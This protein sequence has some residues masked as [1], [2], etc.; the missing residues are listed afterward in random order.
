MG[1]EAETML[2]VFELTKRLIIGES[3][4]KQVSDVNAALASS[5]RESMLVE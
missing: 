5:Y 2:I 4:K 1:P 3:L